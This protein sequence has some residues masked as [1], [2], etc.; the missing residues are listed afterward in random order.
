MKA[1]ENIDRN[2]NEYESIDDFIAG[3]LLTYE[4]VGEMVTE[5]LQYF[6]DSEHD[7]RLMGFLRPTIQEY[8]N[9]RI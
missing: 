7:E 9:D 8:L 1:L 5:L 2:A 3:E 6:A 4:S